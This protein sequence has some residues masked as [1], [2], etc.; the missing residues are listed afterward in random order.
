M[1]LPSLALPSANAISES[2]EKR[3]FA[4]LQWRMF[5]VSGKFLADNEI[6]LRNRYFQNQYG[7]GVTTLFQLNDGRKVWIDRGWVRAGSSA[8]EIPEVAPVPQSTV[9]IQVRFRS[10]ALE[11]K[12]SGSFFATGQNRD[13]LTKWNQEA[14]VDSEKFY[15][16]LIGGDFVP[17][18]PTPLPVLSNGPHFAYAIQWWFFAL[19]VIFGRWLI[20]REERRQ[21]PLDFDI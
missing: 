9:N 6:Y 17:D 11:A 1:D 13:Q 14:S 5:E 2:E 10:D 18:F 21:K 19:L 4:D 3:G 7:F 8:T 20:A 15:F 12:I 16:D